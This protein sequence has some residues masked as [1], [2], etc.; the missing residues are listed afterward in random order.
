MRGY[1]LLRAAS[2]EYRVDL[3]ALEQPR[4][5]RRFFSSSEKAEK[6]VREGLRGYAE[7]I[8][9]FPIFAEKSRFHYFLMLFSS[10]LSWRPFSVLW[11]TS[12]RFSSAVKK[13]KKN[14]YSII[15]IDTVG[16]LPFLD[17]FK[18]TSVVLNHHNVESD[19]MNRRAKKEKNLLKKLI[20]FYEEK[21]IRALEKKSLKICDLHLV[22]SCEDEKLLRSIGQPKAVAVIRNCVDLPLDPPRTGTPGKKIL[23]VGGLSWYPNEDALLYFLRDIWPFLVKDVHGCSFDVVGGNPSS[24]LKEIVSGLENVTLHGFVE[25]LSKFYENAALF[26][27]P[28][29]DGGGTKLKILDAMAHELP[30]VAHRISSEGMDC[31]DGE[32][33]ILFDDVNDCVD[34]IKYIFDHPA[35]AKIIAEKGR[36]HVQATSSDKVVGQN[37]IEALS[38][39][40]R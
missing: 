7:K 10:L 30:V 11:M 14:E 22:C 37:L 1:Y 2:K 31:T 18:T 13:I 15:H 3:L 34:A 24:E 9:I 25:D 40:A 29:R 16:L 4:L 5:S 35:Q 36:A 6:G 28:I 23:F 8:E 12:P 32:N 33:I 17:D 21:K 20:F 26:I 39:V 19:M 27:C 38:R